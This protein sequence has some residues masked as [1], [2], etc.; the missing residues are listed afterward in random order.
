VTQWLDE[1]AEALAAWQYQYPVETI[2]ANQSYSEE[3]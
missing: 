3:R 2:R 1:V